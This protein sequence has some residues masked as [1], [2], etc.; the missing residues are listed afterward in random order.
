MT[1]LILFGFLQYLICNK[2][3]I[4]MSFHFL[5]KEHWKVPLLCIPT[6]LLFWIDVFK[7]II[8]IYIWRTRA[9]L[10]RFECLLHANMS[11]EFQFLNCRCNLAPIRFLCK[12]NYITTIANRLLQGTNCP[13]QGERACIVACSS[14]WFQTHHRSRFRLC[15][16]GSYMVRVRGCFARQVF[17]L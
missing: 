16:G 7:H 3:I 5:N 11:Y 2:Y 1:L 12:M 14:Y 8:S 6:W 10:L 17:P 9:L 13:D 4:N 15:C